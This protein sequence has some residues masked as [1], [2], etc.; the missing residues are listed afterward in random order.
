[1]AALDPLGRTARASGGRKAARC[2]AA[3]TLAAGVTAALPPASASAA[4][5]PQAPEDI[6]KKYAKLKKQSEE[7]SK[8]YRGELVTLEEA[9]RAAERAGADASRAEREYAAARADVARLASTSYMTGRLDM[10]P[11]ISSADPGAAVHDAAVIEHISQNNGRRLENLKALTAKAEKSGENARKKL[12]AV[13]KELK[14]LRSQRARV[15]KLL[16]KYE[17]QVAR[18]Q[19]P[20]G[21]GGAGRPDGAT[22][23]KSPIVGNSMTARMRSVLVE[24]DNRFGPFPTIGCAR[25]GDPQDHGSGTACDF[26]EST[27]GQMPSASA[28][29]HG[30]S[31]AQYLINNASRMGLKYIIWKQRIYDFRSSGGWRQMEDRGSI[32]QNHFDHI[33]VS[34]L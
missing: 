11:I 26:M 18:T 31:V 29:A 14:D 7:L 10:V 3:L 25:P 9:K 28:Q 22:G 24:I 4:A 19:A 2:L 20:A 13:E 33:H 8:E 32:T 21:G 15:R 5:L 16:A 23:T 17:P 1:M 6:K 27:G 30:D 34:V 12:E